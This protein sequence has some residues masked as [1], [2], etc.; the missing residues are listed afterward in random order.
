MNNLEFYE[1][2]SYYL[3]VIYDYLESKKKKRINLIYNLYIAFIII[4]ISTRIFK[5]MF[6]SNFLI[7]IIHSI[8]FSLLIAAYAFSLEKDKFESEKSNL[9]YPFPNSDILLGFASA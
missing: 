6:F 7:I 9:I 3:Y 5:F 4:N 2:N 8:D 1:P